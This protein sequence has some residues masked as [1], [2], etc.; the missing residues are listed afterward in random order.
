MSFLVSLFSHCFSSVAPLLLLLMQ[1]FL[2]YCFF[3]TTFSHIVVPYMLPLFSHCHSSC[4]AILLTLL[5]RAQFFLHYTSCMLFLSHRSS[6]AV[7][8]ASLVSCCSSCDA[9][10]MLQLCVALLAL[11][12]FSHCH[13]SCA[14]FLALL[15]L[16]HCHSYDVVLLTSS[17]ILSTC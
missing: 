5:F 8:F 6:H 3:H 9:P 17:H 7:D 1:L 11:Q 10:L 14:I 12:L 13:S 4:I 2:H 15:L 16:P